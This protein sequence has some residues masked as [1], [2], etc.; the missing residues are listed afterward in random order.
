M[1]SQELLIA[2]PLF[3][4]LMSTFRWLFYKVTA[5]TIGWYYSITFVGLPAVIRMI[6]RKAADR[7]GADSYWTSDT[8]AFTAY[9]LL[10]YTL[11][12]MWHDAKPKHAWIIIA[13]WIPISVTTI[14][15]YVLSNH[16]LPA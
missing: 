15:L 16:L 3:I 6:T 4:G 1:S 2:I 10:F 9:I 8:I 5:E 11:L 12:R 14:F 13:C 7:I